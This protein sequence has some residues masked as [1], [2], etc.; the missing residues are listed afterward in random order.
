MDWIYPLQ[1]HGPLAITCQNE[2]ICGGT[3]FVYLNLDC[4]FQ[5]SRLSYSWHDKSLKYIDIGTAVYTHW[6]SCIS[7]DCKWGTLSSQ[8]R[9]ILL[10]ASSNTSLGGNITRL[11]IKLAGIEDA[12]QFAQL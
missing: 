7:R 11:A 10:C 9:T 12:M 5:N 1:P 3:R 6:K 2:S 8:V 4:V